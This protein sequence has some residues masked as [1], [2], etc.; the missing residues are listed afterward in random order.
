MTNDH[1]GV[2]SGAIAGVTAPR[3]PKR[4]TVV[5]IHG[6]ELRDDY[7]WLRADNWQEM[8]RDPSRLDADIR[9][10]L[11][12]ENT[13]Q[14]AWMADTTALQA[15]LFGEMRGR[16]KEDDS[17][18]PMKDGPW[19]YGSRFELGDEHSKFTRMPR[20]GGNEVVILDGNK[21]AEGKESF[22]IGA[23]GHSPDHKLFMWANDDKGSELY[24]F[25]F[26]DLATGKDLAD[27]VS[28]TN[29]GGLFSADSS[30]FVYTKVDDNHRPSSLW[31]HRIGSDAPDKLVFEEKD[32]GMFLG[33]GKTQSGDWIVVSSH[34]HASA[35]AWLIPAADPFAPPVP[36]AERQEEVEY[37]IEEGGGVLYILTNS[38]GAKDFRIVT[39]PV[40]DPGPQNWRDLVA[41]K[42]GRLILDHGIFKRH[43]VWMERE[44][45]L[46]RIVIHR[47]ADGEQH[48]IAFEE[49]AYS[50]GMGGSLEFDTDVIRFSY[51][52]PTTPTRLYDYNMQT[53]ERVLLKEQEVPSGHNPDDYVTRRIFAPAADGETVPVTLLMRRDARTDGSAPCLLYGYGA[54]GIAIPSGFN[55]D[56]LSLVDRGFIHATAHVRGGKDKGFGWYEN[57]KLKHKQNTFTDFIAAAE[58]L[59]REGYTAKGRIVA[60]GGSAGGMLMGA[61]A[62]MRPDLFGGVLAIV[63][64]VDV[65]NTMLDDS[66][67]LTPPEWN[68]WGNPAATR[69]EFDRIAAYSSYENVRAQPYPA[70][71]AVAGLTDPRVTY[72]ESA[73]WIARL[74]EHT[75]SS[76]PILL[77]THMSAGHAG[78]SGRFKKLEDTALEFAFAIKIVGLPLDGVA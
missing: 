25:R 1:T 33:A 34:D 69:E 28:E 2:D 56:T 23:A 5:N 42:P 14:R 44:N 40:T 11:E 22:R 17:S 12:A 54:Y 53:R 41:H 32:P 35:Q 45:G 13:W 36:V 74:R 47:L 64:F 19:A 60:R 15:K 8:M 61:I 59:I 67:P 52:S 46:P 6:V 51:S 31:A 49:E 62:N 37:S 70:I 71:L 4:P 58:H 57:G 3:A 39:A 24:T 43:L 77:K 73:K 18:V 68:E 9:A 48:A 20:D 72:W 55:T 63:P 27:T 26:R 75:T 38:G 66:L 29:G 65:L 78:S 76:A 16:I 10:H 50:L 21:E 30:I 7:A